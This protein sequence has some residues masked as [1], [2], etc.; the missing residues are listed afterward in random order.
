MTFES[1]FQITVGLCDV[2]KENKILPY[3]SIQQDAI[4]NYDKYQIT[5]RFIIIIIID[6]CALF[7]IFISSI[8]YPQYQRQ[9][10][11]KYMVYSILTQFVVFYKFFIQVFFIHSLW[12]ADQIPDKPLTLCR[13]IILVHLYHRHQWERSLPG[14]LIHNVHG[15]PRSTFCTVWIGKW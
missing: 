14:M 6:E 3:I 11:M 5:N 2:S 12:P 7:F 10:M 8:K 9:V 13:F 1:L 15:V 4:K